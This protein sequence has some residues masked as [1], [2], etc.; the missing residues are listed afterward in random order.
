MNI[1]SGGR[2]HIILI[3]TFMLVVSITIAF[4]SQ[5][6][7]SNPNTRSNIMNITPSDAYALI[8][9]SSN[10]VIIDVRTPQEY[11]SGRLDEAINLDYYSHGFLNNLTSL[12][13]NST[14]L[15]YCRRGIRG[16]L[17]L[18]IMRDLGFKEV[19]N[20][21]GGLTQWAQEGRPMIGEV[22]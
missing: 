8:R 18:G 4:A 16:G 15:I 14:Y 22:I 9:N 2:Y 7:N 11:Q 21:A 19:Y 12:D 13:K 3:I 20:I 6:F 5:D 10:L 1:S 17:A